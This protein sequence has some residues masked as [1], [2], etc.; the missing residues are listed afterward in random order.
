MF[1]IQT[2]EELRCGSNSG[3]CAHVLHHLRRKAGEFR[4][5][6][7]MRPEN[8]L[9]Y[10]GILLPVFGNLSEWMQALELL[11]TRVGEKPRGSGRH[12]PQGPE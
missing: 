12:A 6:L 7:L 2:R 8:M 3:R 9:P 1:H 10:V 4:I 11:R 5:G